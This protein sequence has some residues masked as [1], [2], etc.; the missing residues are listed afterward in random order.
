M[1][2]AK[3]SGTLK[4]K[5]IRSFIGCT[6]DMRQTIRGL[7]FRR[8][9]QIVEREDT[10]AIRGMVHKVRHLVEEVAE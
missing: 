8:M 4:I 10:P 7:G 5:W 6:A 9:H 1:T 2:K 3:K